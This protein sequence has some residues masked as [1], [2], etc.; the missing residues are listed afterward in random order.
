MDYQIPTPGRIVRFRTVRGEILPGIIT[1][2]YEDDVTVDLTAFGVRFAFG[3]E[4]QEKVPYEAPFT[5]HTTY[6]WWW[7]QDEST[8]LIPEGVE[9]EVPITQEEGQAIVDAELGSA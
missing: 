5:H 6:R 1:K 7:P 3:S 2:V 8:L 4:A 9:V